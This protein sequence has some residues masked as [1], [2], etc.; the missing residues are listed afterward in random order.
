METHN[1]T[2]VPFICHCLVHLDFY[3]FRLTE[4]FKTLCRL[5]SL[6]QKKHP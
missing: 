4:I 3:E 2:F 5:H 6:Q 1:L